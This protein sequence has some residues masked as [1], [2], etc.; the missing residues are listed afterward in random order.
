[1]TKRSQSDNYPM[2]ISSPTQRQA[3]PDHTPVEPIP[4]FHDAGARPSAS[5][6]RRYPSPSASVG[7]QNPFEEKRIP[8]PGTGAKGRRRGDDVD[9]LGYEDVSFESSLF[10]CLFW[11]YE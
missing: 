5:S 10:V 4:G 11:R 6:P 8:S 9:H 7:A 2:V 3:N 1:M